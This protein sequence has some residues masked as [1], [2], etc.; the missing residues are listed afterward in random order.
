[1]HM[2]DVRPA[3]AMLG[4]AAVTACSG[5]PAPGGPSVPNS[6]PPTGQGNAELSIMVLDKPGGVPRTYTLVCTDGTPAA[7]TQ[8]PAA[9]DACTTIKNHPTLLSPAP[10]RTDFACTQQYGGPAT[11]TVTGSVDGKEIN[12]AFK[13]TDGCQIALWDAASSVLG[14]RGGS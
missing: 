10:A 11:A 6:A 13:R 3:L 1:M 5:S 12:I 14:S 4:V 8:H 2:L 9:S 7:E